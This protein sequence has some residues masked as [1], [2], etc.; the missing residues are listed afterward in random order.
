MLHLVILGAAANNKSPGQTPEP[1]DIY[2]AINLGKQYGLTVKVYLVDPLYIFYLRKINNPG[3]R[4]ESREEF[5]RISQLVKDGAIVGPNPSFPNAG[6]F[7]KSILIPNT[8]I[9]IIP[10]RY[11]NW[12]ETNGHK[13][14]EFKRPSFP[15]NEFVMYFC[16][17]NDFDC[18]EIMSLL[19]ESTTINRAFAAPSQNRPNLTQIVVNYI[20]APPAPIYNFYEGVEAKGPYPYLD[21]AR[22]HLA[23]GCE[24]IE[25]Y[26]LAGYDHEFKTER[27]QLSSWTLNSHTPILRLL[28]DNYKMYV[29]VPFDQT[30]DILLVE[31]AQYRREILRLLMKVIS[32][33]V[34]N[35]QLVSLQEISDL[36]GWSQP[37]VWSGIKQAVNEWQVEPLTI[38]GLVSIS[39]ET[40]PD[41]T[42]IAQIPMVRPAS[43]TRRPLKSSP[44]TLVKSSTARSADIV[45]KSKAVPVPRPP[46]LN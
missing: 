38:E 14:V 40:E 26:L 11:E 18:Y 15:E 21:K 44:R 20:A 17:I 9:H 22:Q 43:E 33:F 5:G 45:I 25:Q 19:N 27:T 42:L 34:N 7:D 39:S 3:H 31:S 2:R 46:L 41:L 10:D 37:N 1:T 30:P 4:V 35:N 36:G 6:T 8:G 23:L 12:G 32:N 29:L 28:I 16:F 13:I 24:I